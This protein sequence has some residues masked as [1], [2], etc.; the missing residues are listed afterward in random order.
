MFIVR[1]E[2]ETKSLPEELCEPDE[3]PSRFGG[4]FPE[5][6]DQGD[7]S[8]DRANA[9]VFTLRDFGY[10]MTFEPESSEATQQIVRQ[11]CD[12]AIEILRDLRCESGIGFVADDVVE[13][14]FVQRFGRS[15]SSS[16]GRVMSAPFRGPLFPTLLMGFAS[17]EHDE[18]LPEIAA[19]GESWEPSVSGGVTK[20][21]ERRNRDIFFVGDRPR[22]TVQSSACNLDQARKI[23]FPEGL[24]CLMVA[25]AK[26][27][28]PGSDGVFAHHESVSCRCDRS[29]DRGSITPAL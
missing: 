14:D 20:A 17:G 12:Q 23:S 1:L 3:I 16:V 5:T 13:D 8:F 9:D 11:S 27:S 21:L 22:R 6:T 4:F 26:Q 7:L 28:Q 29:N 19:I 2:S 10:G 18:D 15:R 25:I 24:R